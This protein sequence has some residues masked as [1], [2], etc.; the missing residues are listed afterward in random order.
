[1]NFGDLNLLNNNL[2]YN[3]KNLG[4]PLSYN[5]TKRTDLIISFQILYQNDNKSQ[6]IL[7]KYFS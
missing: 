7:K 1:M 6:L 3:I 2:E 4:L 5:N